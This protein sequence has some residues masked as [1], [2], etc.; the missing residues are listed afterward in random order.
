VI[1]PEQPTLFPEVY[2]AKGDKPR[3][4]TTNP[5]ECYIYG[6]L[7][8]MKHASICIRTG[9]P[10]YS[11]LPA[12]QDF[13]WALSAYG[14]VK[15]II[16]DNAP[17]LL[18]KFV[19]LSHYEDANLYHNILNGRYTCSTRHLSNGSPRSNQ[20]LRWQPMGASMCQLGHVLSREWI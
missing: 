18:G 19:T 2:H 6:Y 4:A 8:N 7:A 5:K 13:D 11:G 1:N 17:E 15:E 10:D 16:P 20:Q 14:N 9:E 3:A 12:T